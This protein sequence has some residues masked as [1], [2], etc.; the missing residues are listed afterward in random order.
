VAITPE[1]RSSVD[2]P[3]KII[4][5]LAPEPGARAACSAPSLMV[6]APVRGADAL[7]SLVAGFVTAT[8]LQRPFT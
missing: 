3:S 8:D 5:R 1:Q 6:G 2:A 7:R 4:E